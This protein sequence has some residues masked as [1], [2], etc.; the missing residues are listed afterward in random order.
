MIY[1]LIAAYAA[2]LRESKK[3]QNGEK[4]QAGHRKRSSTQ[5]Q[6]GAVG[7]AILEYRATRDAR[8]R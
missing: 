2:G 6:E 7:R 4:D 5:A 1:P 8:G 3:D